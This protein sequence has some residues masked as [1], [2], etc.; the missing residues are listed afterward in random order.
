MLLSAPPSLTTEIVAG[1]LGGCAKTLAFYPLDTL[2]TLREVGVKTGERRP[3]SAYYAGLGLTLLG[4]LPYAL[5]FHLALW[6]CERLLAAHLSLAALKL[7]SSTCGAVAACLAG[8]PFECLKHRMQLGVEGYATPRA[9]LASTLRRDGARGLYTGLRST[10]VRNV[11]Y[12][13][14]HFGLFEL[15]VGA[16][17]NVLVAGALAGALTALLTT[18]LD[19]VNTRLQTQAMSASLGV[20]TNFT[21]VGDAF[22]TIWR[23]EGGPV[24]LM[25]G[26]GARVAQYTPSAVVFFAVYQHVKRRALFA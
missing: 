3:L 4:V 25:R 12:N 1:C 18:P 19:V 20:A 14:M 11:P 16:L 9:A 8:V 10:L 22:A 17:R 21:G 5:V 6:L 7:C 23:E 13:A 26:A 2:T 15:A 24:A